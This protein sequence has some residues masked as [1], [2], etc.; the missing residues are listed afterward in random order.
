MTS[1]DEYGAYVDNSASEKSNINIAMKI[2]LKSDSDVVITAPDRSDYM[3][4]DEFNEQFDVEY[5]YDSD[6]DF[7]SDYDDWGWDDDSDYNG[8]DV[9]GQFTAEIN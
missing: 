8:W 9:T 6:Y 7:D 2:S 5:D 4:M 1:T 3:T